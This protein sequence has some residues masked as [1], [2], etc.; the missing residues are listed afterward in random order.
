MKF[1]KNIA[2]VIVFFCVLLHSQDG[3]G[4]PTEE[5]LCQ[6][7]LSTLNGVK[8]SSC[9]RGSAPASVLTCSPTLTDGDDQNIIYTVSDNI[10][11]MGTCQDYFPTWGEREIFYRDSNDPANMKFHV[12]RHYCWGR[13]FFY[14]SDN[15]GGPNWGPHFYSG[16]SWDNGASY[17]SWGDYIDVPFSLSDIGS[18]DGVK[19]IFWGSNYAYIDYGKDLNNNP[20]PKKV[21]AYY[22]PSWIAQAFTGNVSNA[23]LIGCIDIP[24]MPAPPIYNKIIVPHDSVALSPITPDASTFENPAITLK[25][26]TS[27]GADS[28]QTITLVYD[29][30]KN[31]GE[32]ESQALLGQSFR[33]TFSSATPSKICAS[34]DKGVLGCV[35]RKKPSDSGIKI[36]AI[37]DYYVYDNCNDPSS[38]A[39]N[40]FRTLKIKFT[41][42]DGSSVIYPKDNIGIREYYAC[43]RQDPSSK[44]DITTS[45]SDTT[46]IFG[47]QFSA[48]IPQFV[49]NSKEFQKI[50]VYPPILQAPNGGK[51]IKKD[52]PA[53]Q[54]SCDSCFVTTGVDDANNQK[55]Q[56]YIVPAGLRD[57][58]SCKQQYSCK[59]SKPDPSTTDPSLGFQQCTLGYNDQYSDLE[60]AY[61]R[62]VYMGPQD[63]NSNP[64]A[65][66][67][68]STDSATANPS[69]PS[70]PTGQSKTTIAQ[71]QTCIKLESN[72]KDFFGKDDKL[73]ADIQQYS[74]LTEND[75]SAATGYADFSNDGYDPTKTYPPGA[76]FEGTCNL[77]L[78]TTYCKTVLINYPGGSQAVS[79]NDPG[80]PDVFGASYVALNKAL[81]AVNANSAFLTPQLSAL[82]KMDKFNIGG[83]SNAQYPFR[84]LDGNYPIGTITNPCVFSSGPD[85]GIDGCGKNMDTA[86]FLGNG[87]YALDSSLQIGVTL[88]ASATQP[89]DDQAQAIYS[90]DKDTGIATVDIPVIGQ[91]QAGFSSGNSPPSRVCRIIVDKNNVILSKAWTNYPISNPCN[92]NN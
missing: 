76:R 21:C 1:S 25:T 72:W 51:P 53:F 83:A 55:G 31:N 43:T 13:N 22:S 47:V 39:T 73:C 23:Y 41:K 70:A 71:D 81:I 68:A 78:G 24:L 37:A 36:E 5:M 57:R 45:G 32:Q 52:D 63:T 58:S 6:G 8:A 87:Y 62:G 2:I 33:P 3:Y 59:T 86:N 44:T 30:N 27:S 18:K 89:Q 49:K 34:S 42:P 88:P 61:C 15:C 75:V 48:I 10:G 19:T 16:L 26:I 29:F 50:Y 67:P 77:S 56:A 60:Q 69:V 20:N 74:K 91:C 90:T 84:T 65:V 12:V 38:Q 14:S 35:D 92:K 11:V 85:S 54:N 46:S 66:V 9:E 28:G 40:S 4:S 64:V 80:S 7:F 79:C 17:A 82:L